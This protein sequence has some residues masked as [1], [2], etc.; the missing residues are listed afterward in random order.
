MNMNRREKILLGSFLAVIAFWL[1]KPIFDAQFTEPLNQRKSQLK[2]L[3]T[4]IGTAEDDEIQVLVATKRL[5]GWRD[6]SFPPDVL[7][8]QSQ[9]CEWITE[10]ARLS[11]FQPDDTLV[12]KPGAKPSPRGAFT[13]ISVD[14]AGEANLQAISRFLYHFHRTD[15]L[16]RIANVDILSPTAEGNPNHEVRIRLQGLAIA[17]APKRSRLFSRTTLQT[18]TQAADTQIA[19][20]SNSGFPKVPGFQIRIGEEFLTVTEIRQN[21]WTVQRGREA[22]E[23]NDY[24]A[25][26]DVELAPRRTIQAHLNKAVKADETTIQVADQVAFPVIGGF[27]VRLGEEILS[28]SSI[29]GTQ[30]SVRRG[31]ENTQAVAHKRNSIIL[32]ETQ[33]PEYILAATQDN[34][35]VKP[36]R[37]KQ[38]KPKLEIKDQ[39]VIRGTPLKAQAKF[40]NL[41]P[42]LGSPQYQL[43]QAAPQGLTIDEKTGLLTWEPTDDVVSEEYAFTVSA[44]QAEAPEVLFSE[45]ITVTL[46]DPNEPP[47]LEVVDTQEIYLGQTL[48]VAAKATDADQHKLTFSLDKGSPNGASI[49]EGTGQF[50]WSP[51]LQTNPGEY[52]ATVVVTDDGSPQTSSKKTVT[53]T[54]VEDAS[55]FTFLIASIVQDDQREAWLYNRA[56]IQRMV[57]FGGDRFAVGSIEAKVVSIDDT[58]LVFRHNDDTIRIE[59]GQ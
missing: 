57:L 49:E 47:I 5:E 7:T 16:Q 36:S 27:H 35:F 12:V 11:G 56:D 59:L 25:D 22:T 48:A 43:D 1:G 13:P 3:Q 24:D 32:L 33:L 52:K 31:V 53:I 18:A 17:G 39:L 30:W 38:Y 14:L 9:Y 41:N 50:T 21:N 10:L 40:S 29:Q 19:V 4:R 26:V 51:T 46:R 45:K 34:P 37:P 42:N 2:A 6:R 44:S 28:V 54:V 58:A 8:A 55:Q 15:L 23:A 20:T